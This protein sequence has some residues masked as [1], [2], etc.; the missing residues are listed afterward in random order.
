MLADAWTLLILTLL[1]IVLG[2]DNLIFISLAIDKAPKHLRERARFFGLGLALLMRLVT[3]FFISLTLSMQ[4][5][6]FY[7]ASLGISIKDLLMIVGGLFLTIKSVMEL[8]NDI[9][10]KQNTKKVN[11]KSQFSLVILQIILIDLVFSIDSILTAVVLIHNIMIISIAFIFSMLSMLF[12]SHYTSK[13]IKSAPRLKTIA[14]LFILFVG[15]YLILNGL[16]IYF[17]KS[18]LYSSFI[19]ALLVEAI[20]S[21]KKRGSNRLF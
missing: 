12:L 13:L 7:I 1:E 18:S 21:L 10:Y 6:I 5:P 15:M 19:F 20:S 14:I 8:L 11:I 9:L 17:P 3:L 2:I 4:K 16:H